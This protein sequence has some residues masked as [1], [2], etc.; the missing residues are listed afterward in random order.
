MLLPPSTLAKL[1]FLLVLRFD[2]FAMFLSAYFLSV[3]PGCLALPV[4]LAVPVSLE[5]P[6]S[7]YLWS[8]II[9]G[10]SPLL[11]ALKLDQ[12]WDQS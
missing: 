6:T 8:I 11:Y 5:V 7:S 9:R 4:C 10:F 12:S 3:L 1:P 2:Q